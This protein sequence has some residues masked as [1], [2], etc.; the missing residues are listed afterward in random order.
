MAFLLTWLLTTQEHAA[1]GSDTEGKKLS[2]EELDALNE[3]IAAMQEVMDRLAQ[4]TRPREKVPRDQ[5][6]LRGNNPHQG[7]WQYSVGTASNGARMNFYAA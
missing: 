3:Q 6:H 2:P 5:V 1:K 4:P 7:T